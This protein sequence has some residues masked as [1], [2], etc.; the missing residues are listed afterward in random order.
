MSPLIVENLSILCYFGRLIAVPIPGLSVSF[1]E[2]PPTFCI[3]PAMG[4]EEEQN[5]AAFVIQTSS[6]ICDRSHTRSDRW[7]GCQI[8]E[9]RKM[10]YEA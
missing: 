2:V 8:Y 7:Q 9:N 10:F 6:S 4:A 3:A 1:G 5:V